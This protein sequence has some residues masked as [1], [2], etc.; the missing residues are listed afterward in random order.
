M[1]EWK[2]SVVKPIQVWIDL[3]SFSKQNGQNKMSLYKTKTNNPYSYIMGAYV[4][5]PKW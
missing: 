1:E 5:C 3:F 2:L 4:I